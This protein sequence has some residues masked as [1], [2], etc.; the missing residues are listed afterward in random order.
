MVRGHHERF[1]LRVEGWE[2]LLEIQQDLFDRLLPFDRNG[3]GFRHTEGRRH[4]HPLGSQSRTRQRW[5]FEE[6]Q[7][8][9]IT[10]VENPWEGM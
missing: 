4:M 9:C 1:I 2:I 3:R 8:S 10:E 7:P 6:H 5:A